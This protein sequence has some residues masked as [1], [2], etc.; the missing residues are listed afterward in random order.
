MKLAK[1]S[2]RLTQLESWH[3]LPHGEALLKQTQQ[4]IDAYLP[5]SF[6]YNLLK[7]GNLSCQ[8]DTKRSAIPTQIHCA[9]QGDGIGLYAEL[10][11]LPLQDSCIDLCI[12]SHE[13]D[14]SNDPHQL[15]REID[16]VLTIDGVLIVSGYN[17]LS[18]FGLRLLCT[19]KKVQ[20]AR[21]FAP[22]RVIDWLHLLGY[23]I[24]EQQHF[25]FLSY[26]GKYAFFMHLE[27]FAQR[28]LP[29]L[30]STYF[31]VAKKRSSPITPIKSTFKFRQKIILR[32]PL[33]TRH[34]KHKSPEPK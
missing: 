10:D 21:L 9:P 19:P 34:L 3:Q 6:G 23:E 14:F 28:Y 29:L 15:L 4:R 1:T 18:G 33:T 2:R 12:L 27:R 11:Q 7:L 20:T 26:A 16:R 31:I 8:L 30:C 13:L 24:K 5:L 25:N 32:Q 22:S 17:P